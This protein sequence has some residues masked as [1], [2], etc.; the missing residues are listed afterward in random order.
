ML[1]AIRYHTVAKGGMTL[2]EKIIYIADLISVERDYKDVGYIRECTYKDIN[3]GM[4][5]AMKFSVGYSCTHTRT[6]PL[7]TLM[8]YNE[9]TCYKLSLEQTNN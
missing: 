2:L 7:S 4:Y 8:A 1:S 3:L 5:E 9:F 6:I